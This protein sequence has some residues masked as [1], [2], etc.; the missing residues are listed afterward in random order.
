MPAD[1][2]R[3]APTSR[4]RG[5]LAATAFLA[6]CT[7]AGL[8]VGA[9]TWWLLPGDGG[10]AA[11]PLPPV[12]RPAVASYHD[13]IMRAAPSVVS[14]YARAPSDARTAPR[15]GADDLDG[16]GATPGAPLAATSR[17]GPSAATSQ[18]S[19]VIVGADGTILTNLHIVDGAER[20]GV[21]LSDGS[22]HAAALVGTDPETDLA[23]LRVDA[24][25][26]P[27]L[28]L[29]EGPA[30]RVGDVVLAIGDPFGVGQTA[31]QGI[32]S[33][34]R[35]RVAGASAWQDFVQIDAAINPGSS[36]GALID[37]LGRL[38]G[39][40]S[41][42][43]Q[44]EGG[45]Q[46]IGFAIPAELLARVVPSIVAEGRVVRGW[47]GI[48]ADDL[49]M[50]PGLVRPGLSGAVITDVL[51]GSPAALAGLERRDV[52]TAVD[53]RTVVD[54]TSLLLTVS[55]RAP[56]TAAR[57]AIERDGARLDVPVTLGERPGARTRGPRRNP[58]AGGGG[59]RV[60]PPGE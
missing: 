45:A 14:V 22:L 36:G 18:G 44:R 60:P 30:L 49:A 5:P 12:P 48:G 39:V 35:R 43:L 38:V 25:P 32:V 33:A 24:G 34:T 16:A 27:A 57:L 23:V 10:R 26:L 42:V 29:D 2:R 41:A 15:G 21:Q 59:G 37:P 9:A 8:G 47:L 28:S 3:P 17:D 19:G 55:A 20:I 7:L 50:F 51:A 52:V 1:P 11:A 40:T 13:G 4:P 6:G 58:G 53:G 46:G 31:T 56:G 54:A